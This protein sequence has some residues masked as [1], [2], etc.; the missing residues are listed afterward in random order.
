MRD[1]FA[2][3]LILAVSFTAIFSSATFYALNQRASQEFMSFGVYSRTGLEGYFDPASNSTVKANETRSWTLSVTNR[4]G[5][6]QLVM[7]LVR[8]GNLSLSSCSSSLSSC[9]PN[10]TTPAAWFPLVASPKQLIGDGDTSNI[11]FTWTVESTSNVT[12]RTMLNLKVNGASVTSTPVVAASGQP[13]RW[14][15]ELWTFD[16]GCVSPDPVSNDCFY[17]GYGPKASPTGEW[18]EVWF[19][20]LP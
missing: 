7:I 19:D 13:F 17:Y 16:P 18:L 4:M 10:G 6:A 12:G 2:V 5:S 20:V 9:S 14:I 3:F 11:N 8:I 1:K 15:F